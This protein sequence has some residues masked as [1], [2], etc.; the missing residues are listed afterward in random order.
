MDAIEQ[1]LGWRVG[2]GD[3]EGMVDRLHALPDLPAGELR[4]MGDV[5]RD[6][7]FQFYLGYF[8]LGVLGARLLPQLR[9]LRARAAPF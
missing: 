2:H 7:L 1:R 5:I 6:V 3:V 9:R 4:A 8:L